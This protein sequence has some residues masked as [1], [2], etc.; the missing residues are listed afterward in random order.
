MKVE[1]R[2]GIS[3]LIRKESYQTSLFVC[4]SVS[5]YLY[6]SLSVSLSLICEDKARRQ[7]TV[8]CKPGGGFSTEFAHAGILNLDF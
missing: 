6:P 4:F 1:S 2:D 7:L 5:L 3:V 8:S